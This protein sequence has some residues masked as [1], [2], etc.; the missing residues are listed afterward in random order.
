MRFLNKHCKGDACKSVPQDC[1]EMHADECVKLRSVPCAD[2][3]VTCVGR[4]LIIGCRLSA[5]RS[6]FGGARDVF[7]EAAG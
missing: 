2:F 6:G 7:G 3:Q 5:S 1:T 4:G